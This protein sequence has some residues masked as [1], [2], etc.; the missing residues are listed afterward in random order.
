MVSNC[1][2]EIDLAL[3]NMELLHDPRPLGHENGVIGRLTIFP[4]CVVHRPG[5]F[6]G[7]MQQGIY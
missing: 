1:C 2:D 5:L 4:V 6:E 7:S 3:R